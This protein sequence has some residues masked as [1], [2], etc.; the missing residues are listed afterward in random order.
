MAR[1]IHYLL[2]ASS[3]ILDHNDE[4]PTQWELVNGA[5]LGLSTGDKDKDFSGGLEASLK[6]C[7]WG[8]ESMGRWTLGWRPSGHP[9]WTLQ[10]ERPSGGEE[11]KD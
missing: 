1:S 9:N 10:S 5:K 11:M 8:E 4:E 2:P 6:V 7:P 3:S